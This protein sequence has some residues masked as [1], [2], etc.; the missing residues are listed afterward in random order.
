MSWQP[1]A[2]PRTPVFDVTVQEVR[3]ATLTRVARGPL[4][5]LDRPSQWTRGAVHDRDGAL[6]KASQRVGGLDEDHF[7][8]ADP[9]SVPVTDN[10]KRLDGTWLYGGQWIH[11]F[12]HFITETIT[13]LWPEDIEVKGIIFHS[14]LVPNHTVRAWQQE[15]V[16]AAGYAGKRL[17]FVGQRRHIVER[18]IVPSRPLVAN[19]W[20][21]PEAVRVWRRISR[22]LVGAEGPRRVLLSRSR[23]NAERRGRGA[24]TRTTAERDRIVEDDFAAAGFTI[25]HPEQLSVREQIAV[26][27][28]AEIIAGQAGSALHLSAFAATGVRIIEI[29]DHRSPDYPMPG[30]QVINA[31]CGHVH[32]FVPEWTRPAEVLATLD[33]TATSTRS[34][35]TSATDPGSL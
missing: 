9:E 10:A 4:N 28:N 1:A 7:A 22:P 17:V 3:D 32:A 15:L 27:A 25:V 23:F 5:V 26:A 19:G 8:A 21:H 29:G 12:G 18:L 33:L 13:N 6:V 2:F 24:E 31:A 34:S 20:A 14:W 30:Q 11:S 16:D 35:T